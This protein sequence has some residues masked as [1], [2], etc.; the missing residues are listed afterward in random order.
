MNGIFRNDL[1]SD[2]NIARP[3]SVSDKRHQI[4]MTLGYTF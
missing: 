3:V 1:I 4:M 2:E